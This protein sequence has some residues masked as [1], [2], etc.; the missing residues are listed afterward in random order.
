MDFYAAECLM[1][2]IEALVVAGGVTVMGLIP[3][4]HEAFC[5]VLVKLC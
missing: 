2:K 4:S 1:L 5:T 3:I